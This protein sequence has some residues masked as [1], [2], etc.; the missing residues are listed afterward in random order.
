MIKKRQP[1]ILHPQKLQRISASKEP[2]ERPGY[3]EKKQHT[4]GE[5]KFFLSICFIHASLST[6]AAGMLEQPETVGKCQGIP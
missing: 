2:T 5:E 1:S 6:F 3:D 4:K